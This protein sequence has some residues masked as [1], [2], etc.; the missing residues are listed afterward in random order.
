M[1]IADHAPV[2]Q[3]SQVLQQPSNTVHQ[4]Q[5]L[6]PIAAKAAAEVEAR[7]HASQVNDSARTEGRAIQD[8]PGRGGNTP[9][10]GR[11]RKESPPVEEEPSKSSGHVSPPG[12]GNLVDIV[13]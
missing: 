13:V 9:G 6:A 1:R 11:R 3:G 7:Q 2:L 5:V 10:R 4:Q 12:S 8:R